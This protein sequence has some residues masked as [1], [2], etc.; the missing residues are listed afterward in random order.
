MYRQK[1]RKVEEDYA[2]PVRLLDPLGERLLALWAKLE[3]QTKS[4][5]RA[6]DWRR[7]ALE[8]YDALRDNGGKV[9]PSLAAWTWCHV[10]GV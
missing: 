6:S 8:Y 1:R 10:S 3:G 2:G 4:K 5:R 9:G 7:Q